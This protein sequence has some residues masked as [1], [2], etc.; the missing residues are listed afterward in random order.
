MTS[1]DLVSS[2]G[3]DLKADFITRLDAHCKSG[4]LRIYNV[5]IYAVFL[6]YFN[7]AE[8]FSIMLYNTGIEDLSAARSIERCR[9]EY[10]EFTVLVE[11]SDIQYF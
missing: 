2:D 6:D 1:C 3:I 11:V 10:D 9:F 5:Q 7:N 8:F 4:V